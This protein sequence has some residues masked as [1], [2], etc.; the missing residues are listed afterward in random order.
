MIYPI[1]A[2]QLSYAS[3]YNVNIWIKQGTAFVVGGGYTTTSGVPSRQ[4]LASTNLQHYG[5]FNGQMLAYAAGNGSG[6]Y[7]GL[8]AGAMVNFDPASSDTGQ[9]VWNGFIICDPALKQALPFYIPGTSTPYV[10]YGSILVASPL[11]GWVIR[12]QFLYG[13]NTPAL[14]ATAVN[15]AVTTTSGVKCFQS[16]IDIP[17]NSTE[18]IFAY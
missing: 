5:Y 18:I 14:D 8:T 1:D 15:T 12:Q 13:G 17:N 16:V 10:P 3:V 4:L 11:Q 2:V 6:G 7:A 9:A